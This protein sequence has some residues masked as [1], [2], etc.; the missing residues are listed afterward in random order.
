MKKEWGKWSLNKSLDYKED[1]FKREITDRVNA[2]LEAFYQKIIQIMESK[3]PKELFYEKLREKATC[4]DIVELKLSIDQR[5]HK[6]RLADD[7]NN[8]R[9]N[10]ILKLEWPSRSE[11]LSFSNQVVKYPDLNVV[12]LG[13]FLL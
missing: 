7:E 9:I 2:S 11:F 3:L 8:N 1:L 12:K 4:R 6:L 10:Q 5:D 13:I